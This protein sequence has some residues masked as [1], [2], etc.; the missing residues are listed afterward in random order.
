MAL[1]L[2]PRF[3]LAAWV[4]AVYTSTSRGCGRGVIVLSG[5]IGRSSR[6]IIAEKIIER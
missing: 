1:F 4:G 6:S 5:T 3:A 2:C